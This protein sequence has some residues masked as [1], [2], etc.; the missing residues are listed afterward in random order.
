MEDYRVDCPL[1]DSPTKSVVTIPDTSV[2]YN[3]EAYET[4]PDKLISWR[5]P[6]PSA[7]K[8][9]NVLMD[10]N[11]MSTCKALCDNDHHLIIRY[12]HYGEIN[13][14]IEPIY[15]P[16]KR[17]KVNCPRCHYRFGDHSKFIFRMGDTQDMQYFLHS[18]TTRSDPAYKHI[19]AMTRSGVSTED[20]VSTTTRCNN[21]GLDIHLNY[22]NKKYEKE[23]KYYGYKQRV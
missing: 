15:G 6:D 20:Q 13:D 3:I 16:A 5:T 4:N 22:T 14:N 1:C 2:I 10:R 8:G 12:C 19:E 9:S 23:E 7:K 18:M 11:V 17:P 21:C